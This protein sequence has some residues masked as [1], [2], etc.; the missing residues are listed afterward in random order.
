MVAVLVSTR[1]KRAF[2]LLGRACASASVPEVCRLLDQG[3][4]GV[5]QPDAQ[6]GPLKCL[7]RRLK[8]AVNPFIVSSSGTDSS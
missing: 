1:D 6:V 5:N 8:G 3:L 7:D 4:A 2:F